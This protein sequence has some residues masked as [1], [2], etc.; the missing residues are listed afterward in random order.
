LA[1]RGKKE[2]QG[3]R[4]KRPSDSLSLFNTGLLLKEF[5]YENYCDILCFFLASGAKNIAF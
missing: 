2:Q 1:A 5:V 4:A 3:E